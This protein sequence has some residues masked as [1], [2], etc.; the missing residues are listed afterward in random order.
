MG[1][2]NCFYYRVNTEDR[3]IKGSGAEV[4]PL[5]PFCLWRQFMEV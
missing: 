1:L 3:S 5:G 2:S 4:R